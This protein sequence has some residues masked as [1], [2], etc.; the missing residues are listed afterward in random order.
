MINPDFF[1]DLTGIFSEKHLI[2]F[3]ANNTQDFGNFVLYNCILIFQAE[4]VY[5]KPQVT[6]F[7]NKEVTANP[8]PQTPPKIGFSKTSNPKPQTQ[9]PKHQVYPKLK[10]V[11]LSL[12]LNFQP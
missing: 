11:T 10:P 12:T 2:H 6:N 4:Q 1:L 8:K 5:S 3:L 9:N 7:K